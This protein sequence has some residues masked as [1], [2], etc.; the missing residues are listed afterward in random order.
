MES[1]GSPSKIQCTQKTADLLIAAGK[2]HWLEKRPDL[3][4][5]KGKG[6]LQTYWAEPPSRLG[7]EPGGDTSQSVSLSSEADAFHVMGFIGAGGDT[8]MERLE[9]LIDWIVDVFTS[10]LKRIV[11]RR[12]I[13]A[14]ITSK[15]GP[16]LDLSK[17]FV[18]SPCTNPRSEVCEVIV[19]PEFEFNAK[20]WRQKEISDASLTPEVCWQ[21]R[22]VVSILA[23]MVRFPHER[24]LGS[25][26]CHVNID[27]YIIGF[28]FD[29]IS[30]D[31]TAFT[32]SSMRLTSPCRS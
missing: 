9:R 2:G 25:L 26:K 7:S 4:E 14:G 8:S 5:A 18:D 1:N 22:E 21:L 29:H 19:L 27:P 10:L 13:I 15:H 6:K 16:S 30:I 12:M 31:R 3:V 24:R 11:A 17:E 28:L 32:T 20:A 23:Y